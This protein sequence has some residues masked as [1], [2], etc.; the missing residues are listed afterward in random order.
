M[1]QPRPLSRGPPLR[2]EQ[3]LGLTC[4]VC[5]SRAIIAALPGSEPEYAPG[6]ILLSAGVPLSCW[7]KR[8]WPVLLGGKLST[9]RRGGI[10]A[11]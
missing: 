10:N 3:A 2:H 9:D 5:G 11:C 8:C 1:T 7:C 4:A 6:G